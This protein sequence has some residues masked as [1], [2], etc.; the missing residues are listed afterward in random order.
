MNFHTAVDIYNHLRD[1]DAPTRLIAAARNTVIAN[2]TNPS[3]AAM[4]ANLI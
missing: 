4:I 2:A 1:T 3:H